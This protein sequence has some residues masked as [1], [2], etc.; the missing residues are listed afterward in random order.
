M[1]K[2]GI[3]AA[4]VALA[5]LCGCTKQ[6]ITPGFQLSQYP[7]MLKADNAVSV[8]V[9]V[10]GSGQTR[11]SYDG[12]TDDQLKSDGIGI[13]CLPARKINPLASDIVFNKFIQYDENGDLIN[14]NGVYWDN[15]KFTVGAP[16]GSFSPGRDMY[17]L[18]MV[19]YSDPEFR[20]PLF[21]YY[22]MSSNYGYDFYGYAP[23]KEGTVESPDNHEYNGQYIYVKFVIDGTQDVIY[24]KSV[25]PDNSEGDHYSATYFRRTQTA[26]AVEMAFEHKLV[27]FNFFV[28]P[29]PQ[30]VKD[31]QGNLPDEPD[32]SGVD[33]L[34]VK[35]VKLVNMYD[36]I[37][38]C[39]AGRVTSNSV[40]V[41]E[42]GT[43]KHQS[44]TKADATF[45][46]NK[47]DENGDWINTYDMLT[48][49]DHTQADPETGKIKVGEY[50]MV[51][52]ETSYT[53]E[54]QLCK[55]DD[56]TFLYPKVRL[57]LKLN[58]DAD[59]N[60]VKFKPGCEYN[61]NLSVEGPTLINLISA[62]LAE[63]QEGEDVDINYFD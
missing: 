53:M 38:M 62:N 52:P 37:R 17:A 59:G 4:T 47:R 27:K 56:P 50:M 40:Y 22:P 43:M 26:S 49:I 44:Y 24:G 31:A 28:K 46:L 33:A 39:V 25:T 32:Y 55:K 57:L 7:I 36:S 16:N 9:S 5:L 48:S 42:E 1:R 2:L 3:T 8:D 45:I 14:T 30:S 6:E 19:G 20:T 35:S 18:E 13:Y 51:M 10:S 12:I 15:V 34:A 61:I 58:E 11:A 60:P 21:E 63:W 29:L 54:V 23:F 41:K